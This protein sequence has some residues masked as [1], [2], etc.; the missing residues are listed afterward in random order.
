MLSVLP[1]L[2]CVCEAYTLHHLVIPLLDLIQSSNH[3]IIV[4]LVAK[5]PLH[6]HQQVLHRDVLTLV[7]CA[8]PF[9]QIPTETGEDVGVHTSLIILLK[10]GIYVEAPEC[11]HHLC[12]WI[13]RLED[14]HIQSCRRQPFPLPT[15]S[16]PMLVTGSVTRSGASIRVWCAPVWGGRGQTPSADHSALG[17]R[18]P[19][20]RLHC[21]S[22][23]GESCL[24][25]FPRPRDSPILL[26]YT[27]H[28]LA[29][30]VRLLGLSN[31]CIMGRVHGPTSEPSAV[32]GS[33]RL[34][35][36]LHQ[37]KGAN[38]EVGRV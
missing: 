11:V 3:G 23:A 18:W 30:G 7:Q 31:W 17:L 37:G 5:R 8:G 12:P 21:P 13:G 19:S 28:Q 26:R 14:R 32:G 35:S 10:K 27:P 25:L 38:I 29:R 24:S 9:T 33:D 6:V 4:T 1:Q 20:A 34:S 22:M 16:V 2:P 15:P 36:C